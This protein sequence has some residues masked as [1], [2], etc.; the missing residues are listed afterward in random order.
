MTYSSDFRRKVLSVREKGSSTLAE[1][2]PFLCRA[3]IQEPW[4]L[5]YTQQACDRIDMAAL[6]HDVECY[7]DAYQYERSFG[8]N[9]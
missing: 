3:L 4:S 6:A 8:V 5:A 7:P 1:G 9:V 2:E